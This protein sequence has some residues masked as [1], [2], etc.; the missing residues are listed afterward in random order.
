MTVVGQFISAEL[1]VTVFEV[2]REEHSGQLFALALFLELDDAKPALGDQIIDVLFNA[3]VAQVKL[4]I[5]F[6]A[7]SAMFPQ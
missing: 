1:D 7:V 6:N 3:P 2:A 4:F 5:I